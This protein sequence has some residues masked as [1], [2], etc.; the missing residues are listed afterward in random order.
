MP[1]SRD[2]ALRAHEPL[3][4]RRLRDE[5]RA[6]DLVGRQAAERAQRQRDLRV[7][8]ERRMAAGED[9]LEPLVG[10]HGLVQVVV[11]GLAAPRAGASS[12]ASV[13]SRRMRSIARL[14]AVDDEPARPGSRGR[15]RAASARR[16]SRTPPA[17][18]PRRGRSRRGSRSGSRG[19]GPT[20]RGRPARAA[21][22]SPPPAAPRPRRPSAPPGCAPRSRSPRR[23]RRPRRGRSR[24]APPW[25]PRTARR[26]SASRRSATRTVVAVSARLQLVAADDARSSRRRRMYSP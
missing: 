13:R 26:S 6:R 5:E 9:E 4:H 11:H 16:R 1:A 22:H 10:E 19:R 2:L 20:R 25:S 12:R 23:G 7:E 18:P 17:R 15:R 24:R 8:R 14:R 3:R 21:A